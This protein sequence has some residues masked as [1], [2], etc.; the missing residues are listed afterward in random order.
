MSRT[1][2]PEYMAEKNRTYSLQEV[3]EAIDNGDILESMAVS[4]TEDRTVMLSI[5]DGITGRITFEDIEFRIDGL[6]TKPISAISRVGRHVK[7]IPISIKNIEEGKY[8]VECSRKIAQEICYDE[9]ISRLIP[10]DIID[11]KVV[12][13]ERYGVFCDI[14]CGIVALLPT[15]YISVTHIVD[16]RDVLSTI[17]KLKVVVRQIQDDG[18]IQLTHKELLGTWDEE[19]SKFKEGQTVCGAVI[20]I[21]DYGI[22]VR[23][24]QNLSGLANIPGDIEVKPGDIVSVHISSITRENM[25]V[26]LNIID[27]IS[28]NSEQLSFKYY[29]EGPHIDKWVYTSK[30]SK[31]NK[32]QIETDFT[33]FMDMEGLR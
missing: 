13:I 16:P 4:C 11:A 19:I 20:S 12:K 6:E 25:K 28:D 7:Y 15:N 1:F 5:G 31:S 14:G 18:K 33:L 21:K 2:E 32:R 26:K 29:V 9:Y 27:K 10:G 23:I 22:F 3:E 24:S 8:E 30:D 17:K